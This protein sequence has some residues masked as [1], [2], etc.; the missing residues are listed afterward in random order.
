MLT[1]AYRV[2][3]EQKTIWFCTAQS[4]KPEQWCDMNNE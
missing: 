1:G 3:K 4:R 2:L